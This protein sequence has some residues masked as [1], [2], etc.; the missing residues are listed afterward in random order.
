MVTG[1]SDEC[2]RQGIPFEVMS[3]VTSDSPGTQIEDAVAARFAESLPPDGMVMGSTTATL[4]SVAGAERTGAVIGR[5]FDAVGKE[6]IPFLGRF[7]RELIVLHEDVGQA[8]HFLAKAIVA[9]I[10]RRAPEQAQY[11]DSPAS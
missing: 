5:D 3:G 10:E 2:A 9:A 11:L 6:A 7:R 1:F 8:G 4:A